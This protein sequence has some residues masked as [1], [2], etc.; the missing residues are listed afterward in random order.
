MANEMNVHGDHVEITLSGELTFSS[1]K[2]FQEVM[3]SATDAGKKSCIIDLSALSSI[4]SAGIGMLLFANDETKQTNIDLSLR[5]P[6][7][8]VKTVLEHTKI[9]EVIPIVA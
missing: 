5:G 4:D 9:N 6:Q 7:G 3:K 8:P 2:E 1:Y